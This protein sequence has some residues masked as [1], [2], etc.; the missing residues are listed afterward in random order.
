MVTPSS[1][2]TSGA[3][4]PTTIG[5]YQWDKLASELRFDR[6]QLR[7]I[8]RRMAGALPDLATTLLRRSREDGLSHPIL[9]SLA[10]ALTQRCVKCTA[11][12]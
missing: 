7:A 4:C 5:P 1:T 11:V 10:D 3:C 2:R 9:A 6:A 8:L 12:L